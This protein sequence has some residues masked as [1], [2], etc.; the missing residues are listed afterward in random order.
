MNMVKKPFGLALVMGLVCAQP[1]SAEVIGIGLDFRKGLFVQEYWQDGKPHYALA[2]LGAEGVRITVTDR[3]SGAVLA[4]PWEVKARS[5]AHVEAGKVAG[6][7][8]VQFTLANGSSL[9]LL[10]APV[11][12]AQQAK[13]V[14]TTSDGMNGSGGRHAEIWCEQARPTFKSEELIELKL[15]V[16]ANA[17]II[18]YST[19]QEENRTIVHVPL[20]EADC[21]TLPVEKVGAELHIRTNQPLKDEPRHT[22]TLRFKA[23]RVTAPTMVMVTG[24]R[25]LN[26]AGG[27]GITRGIVV[28]PMDR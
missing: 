26:N 12:P 10:T 20:V 4:G 7:D 5:V 3:K 8:L 24:W 17:G 18:K 9:G 19:K 22:V 23:P 2:N 15:V 1:T 16:P 28:L 6:N 13:G 14:L 11:P 21:A 27:H 25:A